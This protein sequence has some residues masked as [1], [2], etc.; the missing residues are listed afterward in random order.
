MNTIKQSET[1]K[2]T[3]EGDTSPRTFEIIE[4]KNLEEQGIEPNVYHATF[5]LSSFNLVLS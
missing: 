2:Q 5:E 1:V 4:K 3:Q